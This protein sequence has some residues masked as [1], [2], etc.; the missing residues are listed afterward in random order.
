MEGKGLVF[1]SILDMLF[2]L[3]CCVYDLTMY[4]KANIQE[5]R[6]AALEQTLKKLGVER[7]S[8]EDVQK[9]QWEIPRGKDRK[10]DSFRADCWT[11]VL[12]RSQQTAWRFS[13]V[14]VKQSLRSPEKLFVLLD[15]YEIMRELQPEVCGT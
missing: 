9:M 1:I 12:P 3:K 10:L 7:L 13:S 14:L 11:S 8:K 4:L 15:M 6:S 2:H 5:A